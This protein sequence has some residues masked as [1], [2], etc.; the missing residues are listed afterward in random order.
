MPEFKNTQKTPNLQV[1]S[2]KKVFHS[3]VNKEN[4]M[5]AVGLYAVAA[6]GFNAVRVIDVNYDIEDT[7]KRSAATYYAAQARNVDGTIT[8]KISDISMNNNA[9]YLS[10]ESAST[11]KAAYQSSQG[12][13]AVWRAQA[14][15]IIEDVREE[16]NDFTFSFRWNGDGADLVE[17]GDRYQ[18][19]LL[20]AETAQSLPTMN[21]TLDEQGK[22]KA[23]VRLPQQW[24]NE[25]NTRAVTAFL[26]QIQNKE[27]GMT[28]DMTGSFAYGNKAGAA[29]VYQKGDAVPAAP[30]PP[31]PKSRNSGPKPL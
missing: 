29:G 16:L 10:G 7:V 3:V 17:L 18:L 14:D 28:S 30:L 22:Y 6:L 1:E 2:L 19:T 24:S 9:V 20:P 25:Q 5:W 12:I 31:A 13:S 27:A 4:F 11:A 26:K 8:V 15:E 21:I 23:V